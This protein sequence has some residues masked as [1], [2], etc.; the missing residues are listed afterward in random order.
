MRWRRKISNDK[1]AKNDSHRL[2][3]NMGR[4]VGCLIYVLH[5]GLL[6]GIINMLTVRLCTFPV[7]VCILQMVTVQSL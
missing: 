1:S 6:F 2:S 3:Q 4:S 7:L 5:L